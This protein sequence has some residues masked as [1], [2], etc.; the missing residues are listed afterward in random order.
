MAL[1]AVFFD[2]GETLVDEERWWRELARRSGLQPHVVWAALGVTIERGEEHDALW[3]H[4]GIDR[5]DGWWLGLMYDFSDLYPDAIACLE[6][7][8][9]RGL[10][11]GIAG[12]QT[13]QLERWAREAGLP[14]D[15]IV[16]S[17]S[18]GVRKPDPR[19]F[20]RIVELVG[21]RSQGGRLRRRPRG[22]RRPPGRWRRSRRRARQARAVG[23][24][25]ADTARGDPRAG[26]PRLLA[27]GVSLA[28][29]TELR[30]GIGYDAHALDEG[31]PLV[32]G[33][34]PIEYPRGLAGHSDGDVIVHALID[35]LL[36]A[37]NLGDIG[38]LF[39][40]DDEQ[41]RGASSLDL[42][43]EA[44]REVKE[45]G[46]ELVNADCVLIGEE[47]RIGHAREE[48]CDRLA[49]ALG[50]DRGRVTV[51]ATTTDGLGFSG[52]GEGL[53]AQ[54]VAL[55]QRS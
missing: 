36:G 18:L 48:M 33:G 27:G 37:A 47:P 30:V 7:V 42:L 32:L 5:P 25:A 49:G 31:V 38:T 45:S 28:V 35:A 55:L 19:F 29:V 40:S 12:N 50:A 23:K 9:A 14:A 15:I 22:Q 39:P 46:W 34:V 53:A 44:Y 21:V 52:R 20:E 2:V 26:R 43:W 13:E 11:V 16:S 54:A 17:A 10:R 51:R 24:A 1:K 41:Y 4:L 6:Q 3:G 8:Q